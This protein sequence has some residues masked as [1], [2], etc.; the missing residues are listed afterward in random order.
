MREIG[1]GA[2]GGKLGSV[3]P[4]RHDLDARR[5]AQE[6]NRETQ[7][8]RGLERSVPRDE[9][10]AVEIKRSNGYSDIDVAEG[11]RA[12]VARLAANHP[13]V[14]CGCLVTQLDA[15]GLTDRAMRSLLINAGVIW[16]PPVSQFYDVTPINLAT[17]KCRLR[18]P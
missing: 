4:D 10:S 3:V 8:L 6:R 9:R 11:S 5:P 7:R 2:G 16:Q 12:A 18:Y 1:G 14:G 15:Y 13:E 17:Y